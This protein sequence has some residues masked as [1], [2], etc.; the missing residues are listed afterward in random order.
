MTDFK[1]DT[2]DV[3]YILKEQLNY[4]TLCNL[5]PF[6]D[7]NEKTLDL[8][9]NEAIHFAKGV[10]DPLNQIAEETPLAFANG[11]VRCPAEFKKAFRQYGNDGWTAAVGDPACGG[12]GFPL[13]MRIII[14]EMMYG[15][16][17]AFNSAPS[18]AFGAARLIHSFGSESL[19]QLFVS[20][21]FSGTWSGTMCLTE[22]G[23][24]SNLGALETMAY[25]EGDHFRIKGSKIFISWG[26]H[27]LTENI[28]HLVLARIDGAPSGTAGISLFVVPKIRVNAD[29]TLAGPNDVVCTGIEHKCGLHAAPTA[30]LTF[31]GRDDCIGY[32]CGEKNKGLAHMFQMM[33]GARINSAVSGMTMAGSA[34]RNAL[35]YVQD[36]VQGRDIAGRSEGDVTIIHHPDVRRMLLWMKAAADG[37]RSMVYTAAFW[38]DLAKA[39]PPGPEKTR[40]QNLIDFMTPVLKAYCSDTGFRVCETA[41]QCLGGYGYCQDYPIERYLRDVKIMSLYEGTNGIQSMDLMG[42]KMQIRDGGCFKAFQEE[43]DGFCATHRNH[44]VLKS[45]VAQLASTAGE[46]WSCAMEMR[47][48]MKTDPLQWASYTY[49]AL[50]AFGDLTMAWR[51]LDMAVIASDRAAKNGRKND[52]FKGKVYQATWFVDTTLPHTIA[53]IG[54]CLRAGREIVEIPDNAF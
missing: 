4:G 47:T 2:R 48:R 52:F 7:L 14:N 42:R 31:G 30:A 54:T 50:L 45:Q 38:E 24:G 40:Y 46:L 49:P 9:V 15:A 6:A 20:K 22:P 34:Y 25:P 28:I 16:C 23:A 8:M 5:A 19:K 37:M 32:L 41:M 51:L 3:F 17:Q 33:N 35:A 12:Q 11:E 44:P 53:R 18:L 21:M 27:D 43:I 29:G 10:L 36:R 13:M 39:L 26:E 1:I